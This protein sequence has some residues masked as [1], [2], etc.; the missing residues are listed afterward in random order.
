MPSEK[1]ADDYRTLANAL[2]QII[3]TCDAEGRLEWVNDR[4]LELTGLTEEQSLREKGALVAVH[5]DDRDQVA[6]CFASALATS[7]PSEF[8]YRIRMR[9][10]ASRSHFARVRP[11]RNERGVIARWVAAAFDMEERREA[12]EELRASERRFETAF[13]LNPQPTA[14]TRFSD[15]T[16]LN[17]NDA[18]RKLTGYSREEEVGKPAVE[19]GTWSAAQR[20]AIVA[21]VKQTGTV[22]FDIP[23]R[24]KDGRLLTLAIVSGR[25]DFEGEPCLI[26]VATDVTE[27]RAAEAAIRES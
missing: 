13:H 27:R 22:E 14:I 9:D 18:F 7:S 21:S 19:L 2:P 20:E 24:T 5:P 15:G 10:G 26:N 8:G 6:Q 16:Y 1:E 23:F 25:I 3:W 12:E 4:W 11:L 17:V